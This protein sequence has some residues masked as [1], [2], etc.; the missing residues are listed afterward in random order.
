[1]MVSVTEIQTW[2]RCRRKHHITSLGPTH[3][4]LTPAWPAKHYILG[5]LVHLSGA[6][7]IEY[8]KADLTKIFMYH[9]TEQLKKLALKTLPTGPQLDSYWEVVSLG[10]AMCTNH[11]LYYKTP[12]PPNFTL[13]R[14]EQQLVTPIPGT[15]H[16]TCCL[17]ASRSEPPSILAVSLLDPVCTCMYCT[18]NSL[19]TDKCI[20]ASCQ[21]I[22]YHYLESTLDAIIA[23]VADRFFIFER[24]TYA[25]RP[26]KTYLERDFQFLA[27]TWVLTVT[28]YNT[29]GIAYDGWWKRYGNE[30]SFIGKS[31]KYTR[32]DLFWRYFM[33]RSADEIAEFSQH[34]TNIVNEMA[35][36]NTP[37]YK[38]VP[39]SGCKDCLDIMPLCDA[40]SYNESLPLSNYIKRDR[41]IAFMEFYGED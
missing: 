5:T 18:P 17:Q 37:I 2:L 33:I 27:Y 36:P 30:P 35:N 4:G 6:T 39:W 20:T 23:D 38:S 1:M 9:A 26:N 40:M 41:S 19:N 25:S 11:Q 22:D 12:L 28:G 3:M 16:C 10:K 14:P 24:K 21:C 15:E 8:P 32:T 13:V 31:P 34:L 7:W 29:A